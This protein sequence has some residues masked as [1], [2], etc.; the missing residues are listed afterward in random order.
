MASVFAKASPDRSQGSAKIPRGLLRGTSL[1]SSSYGY[2]VYIGILLFS[3]F[4]LGVSSEIFNLIG[5][6]ILLVWYFGIAKKQM[7][8]VKETYG[9][10]YKRK[11][12][13][14]PLLIGLVCW[15]VFL[16]IVFIFAYVAE[17]LYGTEVP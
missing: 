8:F 4:I 12:W 11:S 3:I 2:L 6:T 7:K 16:V 14:K 15:I 1:S 13:G 9:A 17:V 10:D 5:I